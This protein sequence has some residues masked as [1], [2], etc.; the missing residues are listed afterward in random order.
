MP[1]IYDTARNQD[2]EREIYNDFEYRRIYG[3]EPPQRDTYSPIVTNQAW[4]E[5][6]RTI[7]SAI[8]D[9]RSDD[10][11]SKELHKTQVCKQKIIDKEIAEE[12]KLFKDFMKICDN[13]IGLLEL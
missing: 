8:I 3:R 13:P 1:D 12:K 9:T 7:H 10:E 6:I 5:T 4:E 2:L 11:I